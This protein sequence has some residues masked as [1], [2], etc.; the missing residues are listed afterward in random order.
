MAN[1]STQPA[2]TEP[3]TVP[4]L[5]GIVVVVLGGFFVFIYNISP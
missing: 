4:M 5:L 2:P 1:D 3:W